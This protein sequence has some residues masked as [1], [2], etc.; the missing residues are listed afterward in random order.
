[1]NWL[2]SPAP[3][4]IDPF[5]PLSEEDLDEL[6]HALWQAHVSSGDR[7]MPLDVL[8]GYLHAILVGPATLLPSQWLP[9][10]WG[11]RNDPMPPGATDEQTDRLLHLVMRHYN[12]IA[13]ALEAGDELVP[14]WRIVTL[15]PHREYDDPRDWCTGFV[16]G[17][18]LCWQDWQPLLDTAQGQAWY[19]PIARLRDSPPIP[20]EPGPGPQDQ[21]LPL[22]KDR[23]PLAHQVPDVVAAMHAYWL[24]RRERE[25]PS[26]RPVRAGA[27]IGRN[28]LCLCGSGRKFK[29]CCGA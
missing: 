13:L 11:S 18:Q 25:T 17:M 3:E 6:H 8:D 22:L 20:E 15:P 1:M 10:V 21:R 14:E 27:R 5:E 19:Q 2:R 26:R 7:A 12:G 16:Q 28:D 23:A 29:K 4:A 24:P 9:P